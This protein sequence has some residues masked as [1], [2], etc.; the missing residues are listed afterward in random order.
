MI[1][2]HLI[3]E[4]FRCPTSVTL[5]ETE[6]CFPPKISAAITEG[7]TVQEIPKH[8]DAVE[9]FELPEDMPVNIEPDKLIEPTRKRLEVREWRAQ[10]CVPDI[11]GALDYAVTHLENE[12]RREFARYHRIFLGNIALRMKIDRLFT[13]FL[14]SRLRYWWLRLTGCSVN[15]RT[16][17]GQN[18]VT[19]TV[20]VKAAM[21]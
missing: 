18:I 10:I 3:F 5:K 20:L 11:A 8:I 16:F 15:F 6:L 12:C 13:W 1:R 4:H 7:K 17:P 14:R 9:V 21:E 2:L 19:F